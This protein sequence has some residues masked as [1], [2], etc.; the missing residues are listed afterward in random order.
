M[1]ANGT[2]VWY[3]HICKRQVWLMGHGIEPE[4]EHSLMA[5]GRSITSLFFRRYE[6]HKEINLDNR[7]KIDLMR[8]NVVM[9]VKK[10]SKFLK[11]AKMQ[12]LFYLYYLKHEKGVEAK[13][14]LSFPEE[15]R[16]V[17]VVLDAESEREISGV[18]KAIED[19]IN[20]P[21]PPSPVKVRY[22][23]RCAYR[24]MCWS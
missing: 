23:R 11:A 3:Y 20:L 5:E 18:I 17:E 4:H 13:G 6:E 12:L 15:R 22:C 21:A 1:V 19:L 10:S 16:R 14:V 9:E 2:L 8:G 24:E 7:I